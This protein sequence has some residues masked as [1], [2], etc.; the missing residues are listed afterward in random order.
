MR[1]RLKFGANWKYGRLNDGALVM[2]I[3]AIMSLMVQLASQHSL[4]RGFLKWI[5][6]IPLCTCKEVN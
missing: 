3:A 6:S 1:H 5:F 2:E 4:V